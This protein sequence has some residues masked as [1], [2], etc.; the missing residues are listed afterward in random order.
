[1]IGVEH[2]LLGVSHSHKIIVLISLLTL[3]LSGCNQ[4]GPKCGC[5]EPVDS[6]RS[7]KQQGAG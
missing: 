6:D 4:F 2:M 3:L 1:M 7:V 5:G